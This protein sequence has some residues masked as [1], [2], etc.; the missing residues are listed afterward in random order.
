M[1]CI[2]PDG[3]WCKKC[4]KMHP[5]LFWHDKYNDYEL[6]RKEQWIKS[7]KSFIENVNEDDYI[8]S[9]PIKGLKEENIEGKCIICNSST[10]FKT[11]KTNNYVCCDECKYK[12]LGYDDV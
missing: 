12:E 8:D 4:Q 1:I 10:F 11:I 5:T 7:M 2:E 3:I 9:L 6:F